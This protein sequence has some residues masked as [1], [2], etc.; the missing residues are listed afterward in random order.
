L[1]GLH[2]PDARVVEVAQHLVQK[3]RGRHVVRVEVDEDGSCRASVRLIPG[4]LS[5]P[6]YVRNMSLSAGLKWGGY[7]FPHLRM[8]D[9]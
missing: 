6:V 3:R 2:I 4:V 7:C 1:R 9:C 8:L 5:K